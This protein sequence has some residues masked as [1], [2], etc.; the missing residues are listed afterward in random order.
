M[1]K[2]R[3]SPIILKPTIDENLALQFAAMVSPTK[4]GSEP[5]KLPPASTKQ[6][7]ANKLSSRGVGKNTRQISL[8]LEKELYDKIASDAAIKNRTLEEHLI[9]H[10]TKRY[11]K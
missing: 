3:K 11:G 1:T 5:D 9:R 10:L 8:A 4:S 7:S 6:P 2:A